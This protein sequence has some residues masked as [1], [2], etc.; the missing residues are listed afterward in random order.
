MCGRYRRTTSEEELARR[1]HIQIP[2]ERDLPISWNIA[3]TQDVLAIRQ[4]PESNQRTLDAL[5]WGLIPNWAKD[6]KIAYK[7][8]NAR[9]ETVDTAPSY[10][11]AFKKR[12]CLIPAD[13]FY[14]WKKVL[15]G[16]IPFSIGM[17]DDAPFVFA[18]LWEGWKDPTTDEWLR[19]CTI[20]TGEPNEFVREIH[21]RMPVILPEEHHD[22]W[23]SG[24][25]GKKVLV[26][27]PADRMKAWPVSPRVNSPKNN[28]PE[29]V[30][31]IETESV[32]LPENLPQLL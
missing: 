7:T 19:T 3:P 17:K 31:P 16:K 1:Y 29:I 13:S 5:R 32:A 10:R 18:G 14:E 4:K 6:P 21:T 2:P 24:E 28:D 26:P 30:T 20:I 15:G 22:A 11:E 27:F 25:A 12:R 23:L 8:I 9:V